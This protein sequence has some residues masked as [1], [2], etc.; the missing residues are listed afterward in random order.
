MV[1]Y[2]SQN[3]DIKD[4]KHHLEALTNRDK[5]LL[6]IG[7][8]NYC[9]KE[10][11]SNVVKTY[12]QQTDFAQLIE[13]PTHIEG[14]LLDQAHIRD[15]SKVHKYSAELHSKYFSDHKSLAVLVKKSF[16]NPCQSG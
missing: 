13:E 6:V 11:S 2:R 3:G 4:L 9:F 15:V 16:G 10:N 12:L 14:H 8:F 5:P 1:L 7:D